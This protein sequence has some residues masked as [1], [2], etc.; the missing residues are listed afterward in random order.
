MRIKRKIKG[1]T[2]IYERTTIDGKRHE[3]AIGK[4]DGNGNEIYYADSR[5]NHASGGKGRRQGATC[6]TPKKKTKNN[7][8]Q[9]KPIQPEVIDEEGE[10]IEGVIYDEFDNPTYIKALT[11]R[12]KDF[13]SGTTKVETKVFSHKDNPAFYG[14]ATEAQIWV[15]SN[16]KNELL[17]IASID[18]NEMKKKGVSIPT[19]FLVIKK[20]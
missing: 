4:V 3:K 7:T 14:I 13:T 8:T 19:L 5:D 15:G 12:A 16:R 17:T 10:V 6:E 1:I 20:T 18:F 11:K 2:Y 9:E